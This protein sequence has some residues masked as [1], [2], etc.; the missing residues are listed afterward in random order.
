[1]KKVEINK[2][3]RLMRMGRLD[4]FINTVILNKKTRER[5]SAEESTYPM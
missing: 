5:V 3:S 4:L 1:M 2:N